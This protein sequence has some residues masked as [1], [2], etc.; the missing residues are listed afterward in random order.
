MMGAIAGFG[1]RFDFAVA[2]D[3]VVRV[4]VVAIVAVVDKRA[5][6]G[7]ARWGFSGGCA[8]C[9]EFLLAGDV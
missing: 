2:D 3:G 4:E 5:F 7:D 1:I 8:G 9:V 6:A